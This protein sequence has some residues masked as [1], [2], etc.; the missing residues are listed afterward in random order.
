VTADAAAVQA[1]V[2]NGDATAGLADG[3][4]YVQPN[5]TGTF[6]LLVA[7]A[8]VAQEAASRLA[9]AG[10]MPAQ[11]TDLQSIQPPKQ[12]IVGPVEDQGRA[13]FGF[14]PAIVLFLALTFAGN[15]IATT[16]G[17]ETATRISEVLLAVLRPSQILTGNVLAVGRV[18]LLQLLVLAA[19]FAVSLAVSDTPSLPTV[20]AAGVA[21]F[22]LG[23]VLYAFVVAA[24]ATLVDKVA[25]VGT[26]VLPVT[27]AL[28]LSYLV[29]I[30]VV[31][32]DPSSSLSIAVSLFPLTAPMAMP[33]R[34]A[35]GQVPDYQLA[36][37]MRLTAITAV[38]LPALAST[39]Y[40]RALVLTGR[41]VP[42]RE[43]LLINH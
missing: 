18:T 35:S 39:I 6:P 36:L 37:S 16:V 29:T 23:F 30:I 33:V 7:Q 42:I 27:V 13:A 41:R 12:V 24:A 31:P 17:T 43:V 19:P 2:R 28:V 25:E 11:V 26:A 38:L 15:A 21:W 3:T 32:N 8:V 9:A 40:R 20:A 5:G 4:L 34:R 1:A 10:L 22:V 14:V